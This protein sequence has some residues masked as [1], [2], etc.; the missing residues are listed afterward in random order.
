MRIKSLK[1]N[2][3]FH[4]KNLNVEFKET[5]N[6][7][8]VIDENENPFEEHS[9]M[10]VMERLFFGRFLRCG[11]SLRERRYTMSLRKIRAKF[12][13][14]PKGQKRTSGNNVSR[15]ENDGATKRG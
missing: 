2:D 1:V 8:C 4:I 11:L 15:Q 3:V 6:I 9:F 7:I 12:S 13:Y 14:F 10:R 5:D